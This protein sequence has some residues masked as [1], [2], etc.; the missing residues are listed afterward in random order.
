[1][2]ISKFKSAALLALAG[3]A[4]LTAH[5]RAGAVKVPATAADGDLF[6]GIRA[7][8]GTGSDKDVI[9]DLGNAEELALASQTI[10]TGDLASKLATAFGAGWAT[11]TDL[12]LGIIG[13]SGSAG[14]PAYSLYASSSTGVPW[15]PSNLT[16]QGVT[17]NKVEA[18]AGIFAISGANAAAAQSTSIASSWASYAKINTTTPPVNPLSFGQFGAAFEGT[19]ATTS[20]LSLTVYDLDVGGTARSVGA[21]KLNADGSVTFIKASDVAVSASVIAFANPVIK[22]ANGSTTV[23]IPLVRTGGSAPVSATVTLGAS[24]TTVS[25]AANVNVAS[26]TLPVTPASGVAGSSAS[27]S[28]SAGVAALGGTSVTLGG[29]AT[30]YISGLDAGAPFLSLTA[31]TATA[32]ITGSAGHAAGDLVVTGYADDNIAVSDV[33]VSVNGG[34]FTSITTADAHTTANPHKRSFS[35]TLSN[36]LSIVGLNSVV[37]RA[38]DSSG[39]TADITRQ[40]RFTAKGNIAVTAVDAADAAVTFTAPAAFIGALAPTA[41]GAFTVGN[42]NA[43][44][45]P[46]FNTGTTAA[47]T[48]DSS[49]V[50]SYWTLGTSATHYTTLAITVKITQDM[51]DNG[52]KAHYIANPFTAASGAA[53][54]A[55][56]AGTYSGLVT[57]GAG[58]ASSNATNGIIN[59][60]LSTRGA[61]TG[62]IKINGSTLTFISGALANDGTVL[63]G[64]TPALQYPYATF[65]NGTIT[66][67]LKFNLPAK[68]LAGSLYDSTNVSNI[69]A[70]L[71]SSATAGAYTLHASSPS[72]G[73]LGGLT[74]ALSQSTF[75]QGDSIVALSVD[76]AGKV[77]GTY[78]LGDGKTATFSGF[79]TSGV[80][81]LYISPYGATAATAGSFSGVITVG[82]SLTGNVKWFRP[83]SVAAS[84]YTAG[85]PQGV[86]VAVAG[87]AFDKTASPLFTGATATGNHATFFVLGTGIAGADLTNTVDIGGTAPAYTFTVHNAT[88]PLTS[89]PVYTSTSG[90]LS[91]TRGTFTWKAIVIQNGATPGFYGFWSTLSTSPQGVKQGL[92]QI[93]P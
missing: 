18:M 41:A 23:T 79:Y 54:T 92:L 48:N 8:G 70:K 83:A 77:T 55:A 25:F 37:I 57:N 93:I 85:W 32:S 84:A 5:A 38:V 87:G 27:V 22:A 40:V 47:T 9:V 42:V 80:I 74:P 89:A 28:L 45:A 16:Q 81:P 39:N 36:V 69:S 10:S 6:L 90:I 21:F 1:M 29:N 31:P 26:V 61:L 66:V 13:T 34:A 65:G 46:Q 62:N 68:T 73:V 15:A 4:L 86:T 43:F 24:S 53:A 64:A 35:T 58:F 14:I 56:A 2:K 71:Q 75:P 63:F 60:T 44:T 20:A 76:V 19:G 12:A 33:E 7:T 11:R 3:S 59:V 82:A 67:V 52:I 49:K 17:S 72:A 88:A 91:G 50:F 30:V 51:I 78:F